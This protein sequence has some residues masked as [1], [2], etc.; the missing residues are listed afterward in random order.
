MERMFEDVKPGDT[1]LLKDEIVILS[2]GF[3]GRL[4]RQVWLSA[5]V[6]SVTK[7][8]L[9]L[10]NGRRFMR[11]RGCEYGGN[12]CIRPVGYEE[13]SYGET[14]ALSVTPDSVIEQMEQTNKTLYAFMGMIDRVDRNIKSLLRPL[15][16]DPAAIEKLAE[17]TRQMNE[18]FPK[19]TD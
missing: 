19:S 3:G 11:D 4:S 9:R 10:K 8:Q 6:E 18:L 16:D 12:G 2:G 5:E 17:I 1:V 15:L 13:R 14:T 7:T